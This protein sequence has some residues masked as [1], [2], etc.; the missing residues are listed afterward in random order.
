MINLRYLLHGSLAIFISIWSV[1]SGC[2]GTGSLR[3][4]I[5][6]IEASHVAWGCRC[7]DWCEWATPDDPEPCM[8]IEPAD[9]ALELPDS[10]L[11]PGHRI[12]FTGRSYEGIGRP[13]DYYDEG[14][15]DGPV[16]QYTSYVVLD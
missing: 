7:P 10:L 15:E 3:P 14:V 8:F 5:R 11:S 6:T 16:F 2:G 12:R 9:P 4:E 13:K 1:L